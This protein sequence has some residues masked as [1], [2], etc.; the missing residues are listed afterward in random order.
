MLRERSPISAHVTEGGGE[1]PEKVEKLITPHFDP[2]HY[3]KNKEIGPQRESFG[4][5][6]LR[7]RKGEKGR[8]SSYIETEGICH[9]SQKLVSSRMLGKE[10]KKGREA[11]GRTAG[12]E[13]GGEV[14]E[15]G[16]D[17]TVRKKEKKSPKNHLVQGLSKGNTAVLGKEDGGPM[18]KMGGK[19]KGKAYL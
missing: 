15:R 9:A 16:K 5:V 14:S 19:G 3:Y 1:I 13:G 12:P 17:G 10:E 6:V 4:E 18:F 7:G 11:R 2:I 8:F